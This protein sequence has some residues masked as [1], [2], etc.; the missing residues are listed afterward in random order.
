MRRA[1]NYTVAVAVIVT[2]SACTRDYDSLF[3]TLATSREGTDSGLDLVDSGGISR[4]AADAAADAPAACTSPV[5]AAGHCELNCSGAACPC[6]NACPANVD[7]TYRC[8]AGTSCAFECSEGAAGCDVTCA[9]GSS[10]KVQCRRGPCVLRCEGDAACSM[11][12]G[13]GSCSVECVA[14]ADEQSCGGGVKGC[15][16]CP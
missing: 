10:C 6:E 11:G 1:A 3:Q 4:G 7:C 5:C 14:G 12:C 2:A 9:A 13:S 15:N 16:R 8:A